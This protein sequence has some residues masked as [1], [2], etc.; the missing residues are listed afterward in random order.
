MNRII[1]IGN[2]YDLSCGLPTRYEDFILDHIKNAIKVAY[3]SNRDFNEKLI[4]VENGDPINRVIDIKWIMSINSMDEL[5]KSD[6]VSFTAKPQNQNKFSLN[7]NLEF[8][9]PITSSD[10]NND[11]SSKRF[12]VSFN[13]SMFK[14][15]LEDENWTDIESHYFKLVNKLNKNDVGNKNLNSLNEEFEYLKDELK[16]YIE[17]TEMKYTEG[18]LPNLKSQDERLIKRFF[19]MRRDSLG[20]PFIKGNGIKEDLDKV[21]FINFN[22]TSILSHHLNTLKNSNFQ[23]YKFTNFE[24]IN[25]HG[26]IKDKEEIIFGYGDENQKDYEILEEMEINDYLKN[27]KSFYYALNNKYRRVLNFISVPYDV[28]SVG[29]SLGVSDRILLKTIL[30]D[31]NCKEIRLFH[32]G[33]KES[34]FKSVIS[35][36]RHFKDKSLLRKKLIAYDEDDFIASVS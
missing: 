20:N 32:R 26:N 24:V 8:L 1:L 9:R 30:G 34:F 18:K 4:K 33:N 7:D 11:I 2:G 19:D 22:Y 17:K 21:L 29:H 13:S 15:L 14:S 10:I 3:D 35:L 12:H 28:F 27:I 5:K 6:Y 25:I 36:S 31:S 23:R 16:R